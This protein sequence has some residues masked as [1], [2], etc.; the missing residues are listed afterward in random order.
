VGEESGQLPGVTSPCVRDHHLPPRRGFGIGSKVLEALRSFL[1]TQFTQ[2]KPYAAY[3]KGETAFATH[4][5]VKGLEFPRVMV[6]MDDEEAGG[7]MFSFD[8]LFGA[9]D[10]TSN[11]LKNEREGNDTGIAR[12]RRLF[13]VTCSRSQEGLAIVAY[14]SNPAKV[15]EYALSQGW[16]DDSEIEFLK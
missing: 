16:F 7:F 14:S 5:G 2:I 3:V 9:K 8:K 4:Q 13:Y 12:T 15:R 11:D 1:N 10:K 6:V